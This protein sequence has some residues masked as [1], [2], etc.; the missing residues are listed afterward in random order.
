[1]REVRGPLTKPWSYALYIGFFAGLIWGLAGHVLSY[2]AFTEVAP[3]FW[4]TPWVDK[5][6]LSS[7]R[8]QVAGLALYIC[9]SIVAA[10][11]YTAVLRKARGPWPGIAYGLAWYVLLFCVIGPLLGLIPS[12]GKLATHTHLAELCRSL[13]WGVFIG[14]SITLEF[15]DDR[16]REAKAG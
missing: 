8:G 1:M 11:L 13:L 10:L 6:F 2:F 12:F 7:W 9:Y 16:R 3:A 14:Y 5:S 15:T 4:L